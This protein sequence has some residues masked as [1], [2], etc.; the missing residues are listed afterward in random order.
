MVEAV[1][2]AKICPLWLVGDGNGG[3]DLLDLG[4]EHMPNFWHPEKGWMF[5]FER[6]DRVVLHP[7]A[8]VKSES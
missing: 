5:A 4:P 6:P 8:M 7:A 1:C 3:G 2:V